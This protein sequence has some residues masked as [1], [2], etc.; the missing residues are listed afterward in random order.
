MAPVQVPLSPFHHR[1]G[2]CAHSHSADPNPALSIYAQT[3]CLP[4]PKRDLRPQRCTR[5]HPPLSS[6]LT[7]Q[8]Q[9]GA[10]HAPG[11]PVPWRPACQGCRRRHAAQALRCPQQQHRSLARTAP[12]HPP[13]P[14]RRPQE[15]SRKHY[16]LVDAV[17]GHACPEPSVISASLV[18][19]GTSA[20]NPTH[21]PPRRPSHSP[22]CT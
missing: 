9:R 1:R 7:S 6:S 15:Q 17:R 10:Q 16:K 12:A 20:L 5:D 4:N 13:D 2:Q 19:S 22:S 3:S 11:L 21:R 18:V 8:D 14:K